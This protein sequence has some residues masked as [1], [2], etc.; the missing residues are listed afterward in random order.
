MSV[1]DS[2]LDD[3][4]ARGGHYFV[5]DDALASLDLS[6]QALAS[7]IKR[8][9][10]KDRLATPRRS[11]YLILRPED[12]V[13]GAPDPIR[14]IDPLMRYQKLD[15]RISFLRAA[16]FHGASLR[17]AKVFQ[18]VTPKQLRPFELGRHRIEFIYQSPAAFTAVN[19]HRYLGRIKSATGSARVAGIELT[20]LDCM[21]YLQRAG[22]IHSV[23]QIVNDLGANAKAAR[24]ANLAVDYENAVVR[25]LGYLLTLAGHL[26]QAK[27]LRP[28]VARAK[29]MTPLDPSLMT[30]MGSR[31]DEHPRDLEWK[32]IIN[33]SVDAGC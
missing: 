13:W 29:S 7:A 30:R 32:L 19:A 14:W 33:A 15:Y 6:P 5:W 18:I 1:L 27:A 3:L 10:R 8:H 31:E 22:G 17:S 16:A 20:L 21:R 4:L 24:L 25:R 2:Y 12:Q 9:V 23:V 11:F 26:R 28:F